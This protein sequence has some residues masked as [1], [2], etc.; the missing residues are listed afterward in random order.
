MHPSLLVVAGALGAVGGVGAKFGTKALLKG[1]GL[2]VLKGDIG[3]AFTRARIT[4][5]GDKVIAT[6]RAAGEVPDLA[7]RVSGTGANA[8]PDFV[9]KTRNGVVK[10]VESL[11]LV[12]SRR[13]AGAGNV[14]GTRK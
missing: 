13:R 14:P 7:G 9:V 12:T 11:G 8:A 6:Q 5:G 4:L 10:V 3:E 1:P 2:K